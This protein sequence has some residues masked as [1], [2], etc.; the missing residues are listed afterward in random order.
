M[1]VWEKKLPDI[2]LCALDL[3]TS[4]FSKEDS[5]I[6][7]IAIWRKDP[8]KNWACV[9]DTLIQP[10]FPI[11]NSWIHGITD[12]DVQ[13]SPRFPELVPYIMALL[14]ESMLVAHNVYF[15]VP[16]LVASL[17]KYGY[18]VK[19]PP[20]TCSIYLR[21]M[22]GFSVP[23]GTR[24]SLEWAAEQHQI[25]LKDAHQA[26][27]DAFVVTQ[28]INIYIR[29]LLQQSQQ[30]TWGELAQGYSYQFL[31]SWQVPFWNSQQFPIP[32]VLPSLSPR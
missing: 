6:I 22:A 11:H 25:D 4:G 32:S 7:E 16:F 26:K 28:L 27:N 30:K 19:R 24:H 12:K 8:G 20:H 29:T 17:E 13:K 10:E 5:E 3:E 1:S 2:S 14:S 15:D 23:D 21:K 9:L 31:E 18:P